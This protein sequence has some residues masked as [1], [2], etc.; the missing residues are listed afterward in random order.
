MTKAEMIDKI[1]ER[2]ND[3]YQDDVKKYWKEKHGFR[4]YLGRL[5]KPDLVDLYGELFDV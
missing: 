5:L 1:V 3:V 4:E 2:V